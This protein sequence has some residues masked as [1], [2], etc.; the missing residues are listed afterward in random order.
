VTARRAGV[1]HQLDGIPVEFFDDDAAAKVH[2]VDELARCSLLIQA[3]VAIPPDRR[4]GV[5]LLDRNVIGRVAGTND[6][7][8]HPDDGA[9]VQRPG[10]EPGIKLSAE[11]IRHLPRKLSGQARVQPQRLGRERLGQAWCKSKD[12]RIQRNARRFSLALP[13][14]SFWPS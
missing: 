5:N 9:C 8:A 4:V 2:C 3:G 11:L 10:A 13:F 6:Q 14:F 12:R 1:H 7:V